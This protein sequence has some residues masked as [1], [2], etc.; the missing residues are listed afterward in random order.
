MGPGSKTL[1]HGMTDVGIERGLKDSSFA[2]TV[3]PESPAIP[4]NEAIL[5]SLTSGVLPMVCVILSNILAM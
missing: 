1:K 2:S 4:L 5:L 3:T